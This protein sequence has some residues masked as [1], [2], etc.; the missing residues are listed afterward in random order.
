MQATIPKSATL[1]LNEEITRDYAVL[2]LLGKGGFG[3]VYLA[4]QLHVGCRKVALKVLNQ[5]F[6]QNPA[7]L[8]RFKNEAA[9]AG[10]LDHENVVK[11]Y[12]CRVTSDGQ[13]YVAME[14]VAG[15]SLRDLLKRQGTLPVSQAINIAQQVAAGLHAAHQQGVVHRDIK[16][17]NLMLVEKE[18][19]L[20]AKVLDFGIARFAAPNLS[21]TTAGVIIGSAHYMSPE[22]AAGQTGEQIDARSDIYSLAMVVYE[23]LAGRVAFQGATWTDVVHQQL[24]APPP[25]LRSI[26]PDVPVAVEQVILKALQKDRTARQPDALAFA[27]ELSAAT[28]ASAATLLDDEATKV[29]LQVAP[30]QAKPMKQNKWWQKYAKQILTGIIGSILATLLYEYGKGA[31]TRSEIPERALNY[32]ITVQKYRDGRAYQAPFDLASEINFERDYRVQLN[33]NNPQAGFLYALNEGPEGQNQWPYNMLF[34]A[35][36]ANGGSAQVAAHQMLRLPEPVGERI[37]FEL[38]GDQGQEKIFI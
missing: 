36:W 25:S 4:E 34:P 27:R 28:R 31:F 22:Q 30:V 1:P 26:R 37:G 21:Q 15:E 9:I 29:R 16:P 2:E 24:H 11:V 8:N 3:E 7:M 10:N 12:D 18:G 33:I 13:V 14:Y 38:D 6:A 35:P 23:M 19:R 17:D 20:I 5:S 32:S